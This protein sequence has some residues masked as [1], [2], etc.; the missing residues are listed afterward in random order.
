MRNQ[1]ILEMSTL[2]NLILPTP[3]A[4]SPAVHPGSADKREILETVLYKHIKG[5]NNKPH[6]NVMFR[7]LVLYTSILK[8]EEFEE[9]YDKTFIDYC[10]R[11]SPG[12]TGK[13]AT[14]KKPEAASPQTSN[15][16][17]IEAIVY[18]QELC[19]CLPQ[20]ETDLFFRQIKKL[21]IKPKKGEETKKL[22]EEGKESK[23]SAKQLEQIMR[24]PRA[25][26]IMR[27]GTK[28]AKPH[29]IVDI[30]FPYN[31]DYSYGTIIN[32]GRV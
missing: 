25:Y 1:R 4:N 28:E 16:K 27:P 19:A 15:F 5:E 11:A 17:V 31:F 24:Y 23:I 21:N 9:K 10:T 13:R 7:G 29:E 6:L 32:Q 3:A 2:D 8:Y 18:I 30:T 26:L 12:A 20:P 14:L 22:R